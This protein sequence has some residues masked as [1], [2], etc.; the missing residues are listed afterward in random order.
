MRLA[1]DSVGCLGLY[2]NEPKKKKIVINPDFPNCRKVIIAWSDPAGLYY[3]L[4]IPDKDNSYHWV[5]FENSP[6]KVKFTQD[7][8][9]K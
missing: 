6:V 2:L 8:Y 1:R 7:K 4:G 3:S 5:T 9:L